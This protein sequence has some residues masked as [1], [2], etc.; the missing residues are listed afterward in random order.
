MLARPSSG[1][2]QKLMVSLRRLDLDWIAEEVESVLQ[3]GKSIDKSD[4]PGIEPASETRGSVVV[5]YSEEEQLR[6]TLRT[7]QEYFVTLH[8]C[9][10]EA[11]ANVQE[12]TSETTGQRVEVSA[13]TAE[14][15]SP[16]QMFDDD[17]GDAVASLNELLSQAL[18]GNDDLEP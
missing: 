1:D 15:G 4:E 11:E 2:V 18:G 7:L 8:K 3:E 12:A 13:A 14:S 6:I 17:Y 5:D 9:W 10:A 16:L